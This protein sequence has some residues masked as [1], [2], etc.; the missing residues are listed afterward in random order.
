MNAIFEEKLKEALAIIIKE[1]FRA[2]HDRAMFENDPQR[3]LSQRPVPPDKNTY[4]EYALSDDYF[5]QACV[6]ADGKR[7][8]PAMSRKDNLR[9]LF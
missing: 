4:T 5:K 9:N 7:W 1:A 3:Y 2:G 8:N 6:V